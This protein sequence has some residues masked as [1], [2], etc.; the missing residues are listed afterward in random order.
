MIVK[1]VLVLAT[2]IAVYA[3]EPSE[4]GRKIFENRCSGCHGADGNGGE[5][6]PAIASRVRKLTDTQ[7]RNTVHEGVAGRM[8]PINVNDTDMQ[9]LISFL[10]TLRRLMLGFQPYRS[11]VELTSGQLLNGLVVGESFDCVQ[12]RTDDKHIHLLRRTES[13]KFR[14]VTSEVNWTTYN[15]DIGG[16]RYTTMTQIDKS[17]VKRVAPRWVFTLPNV[18]PLEGTPIVMDGVM[19]VTSAN[20]CYALDAGSGGQIWHFKRDRTPGLTGVGAAGMNRGVAIAGDK[21]F[22]VTDNAHL[23][24][25]N[26]AGGELV[27]EAELADWHKNYSATS[28]PLVIGNL[29]ISGIAGGEDGVRGFLA[30]FDQQTGKEAWRFGTVPARGEPGA[31][32]WHGNG[33][34]HGSAAT[35]FTG[36]YDAETE[37]LLWPT[38][39]PGEDYNGDERGGDNLYSDCL[40]ALN[41][42]TGKLKWYYQTT[43][44]DLWDWDSAETPLVIDTMWEG[45]PRKLLAQ[46]NR[47]G[48]FYV[49]DRTNGKLLLAKQ[50]ITE[51][52]WATGIGPDGRPL[53][54]PGQE[55]SE[56]GTRVCPSQDGATNWYSPSYSPKTGLFYL[57]T[58][59]KCSI[60]TKRPEE[61]SFGRGFLGGA[62]RI[63][64]SKKPVRL[65]RAI[66]LKTGVVKWQVP[67]VGTANSWGGTLA[68]GTGLVF[69]SED[70]G[71]FAAADANTGKIL[72]TFPT[73]AFWKASPMVYQFDG[74]ELLGVAAGSNI[75]VFGLSN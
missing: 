2:S 58:A 26:K 30:A 54:V 55:P 23:I 59:E 73:N 22:M 74:E 67:E 7:I 5:L 46:G 11:K 69:F 31:E 9:P 44:H 42:K 10:R 14:E 4:A 6:G 56:K 17:N 51:L 28:A 48:F 61:F 25:L 29:V 37:T 50:F 35:W 19:Y 66:D 72:W 18:F 75:L 12:M 49:L 33:I 34:E 63:D 71:D 64:P 70:S 27:W 20:E 43:P 41:P 60:Y 57:Q 53:Q 62:Q 32:T 13:D 47:N 68:T 15:G 8:P 38:G 45:Q 24:A 3:Q 16:N 36:V 1:L 39:N 21:V 65:L 40:L 52:T